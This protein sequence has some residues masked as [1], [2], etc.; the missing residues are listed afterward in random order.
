MLSCQL[1][2]FSLLRILLI[3]R[4]NQEWV[5]DITNI[6]IRKGFMYLFI[7]KDWYNRKIVDDKLSSTLKKAFVMNCLLRAPGVGKPEIIN[8]DQGSHFINS[9]YVWPL[10]DAGFKIYGW[11]SSGLPYV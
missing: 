4:P 8:C 11:Q 7:I 2:L 10:E 6:R 1:V 9:D 3:D 5:V